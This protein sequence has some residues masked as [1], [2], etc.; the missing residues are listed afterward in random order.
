[1]TFFSQCH[2]DVEPEFYYF[3]VLLY[4][5]SIFIVFVVGTQERLFYDRLLQRL[6]GSTA[7]DR[8]ARTIQDV[9]K[10]ITRGGS[11]DLGTG[12]VLRY[13]FTFVSY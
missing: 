10:T 3:F 8:R 12:G 6:R 11:R 2:L 9:Y 13:F 1:M 4:K 5:S 7:R